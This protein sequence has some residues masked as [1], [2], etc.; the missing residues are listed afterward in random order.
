[1]SVF[2][3]YL[4]VIRFLYKLGTCVDMVKNEGPFFRSLTYAQAA[5]QIFDFLKN[6]NVPKGGPFEKMEK[7]EVAIRSLRMV[8]DHFLGL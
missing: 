2:I 5:D 4:F 3:T 7:I 8:L 1:M 6:S